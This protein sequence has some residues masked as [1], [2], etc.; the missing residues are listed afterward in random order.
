MSAEEFETVLENAVAC[1]RNGELDDAERLFTAA[2]AGAPDEGST[3]LVNIYRAA[4]AVYRREPSD[5]IG[6]LPRYL[7]R[8]DSP[9]HAFLAS[10]YL[11]MHHTLGRRTADA[12]RYAQV[13]VDAAEELDDDYYRGAAND[14][15]SAVEILRGDYEAALSASLNALQALGRYSGPLST[16]WLRGAAENN[17]GY[18]LLATNRHE[19]AVP[20]FH[21]SKA[22]LHE[23]ERTAGL[24]DVDLNLALALLAL[25]RLDEAEAHVA[26]ADAAISPERDRLRR[27][28]HYLR[29]EIAQRAGDAGAAWQHFARLRDYYPEVEN[30]EDLLFMIDVSP[31]LL[32]D[33]E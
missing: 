12:E 17:A 19:D 2:L 3:A 5:L 1:L 13:L 23:A 24:A 6:D 16:A 31:L 10:Y 4:I 9:R 27:Y 20:H 11:V 29:G 15:L 25:G 33:P 18:C 26:S 30:L 21:R 22:A 7:M 8:R 32:P 14:S 28:V